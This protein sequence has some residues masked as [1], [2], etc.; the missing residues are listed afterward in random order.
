MGALALAGTASAGAPKRCLLM[1]AVMSFI[2]SLNFGL[3]WA[4][5]KRGW[6]SEETS[7]S[8]VPSWTFQPFSSHRST[9]LFEV[10]LDGRERVG[11]RVRLLLEEVRLI[12]LPG[13]GFVAELEGVE[14]FHLLVKAVGLLLRELDG[15]SDF[16]QLVEALPRVEVV[17]VLV[18][19]RVLVEVELRVEAQAT[20]RA[21]DR[22]DAVVEDDQV[23]ELGTDLVLGCCRGLAPCR[24][25]LSTRLR[26]HHPL[27]RPPRPG[28]PPWPPRTTGRT[29]RCGRSQGRPRERRARR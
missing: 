12:E 3:N 29:D 24:A 20:E 16:L 13:F 19:V 10:V 6:S 7:W 2:G 5:R 23:S 1:T 8:L 25:G 4:W 28:V 11:H 21:A 14:N 9:S 15:S 18:L 27:R 17:L 22:L 26:V